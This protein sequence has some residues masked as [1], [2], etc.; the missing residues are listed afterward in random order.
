MERQARDT[1]L[2]DA[3]SNI[4]RPYIPPNKNQ[5]PLDTPTSPLPVTACMRPLCQIR[6]LRHFFFSSLKRSL[7]TIL[8]ISL[9]R[10]LLV[11]RRRYPKR[12][13][14]RTA[15]CTKIAPTPV[16]DEPSGEKEASRVLLA[17]GDRTTTCTSKLVQYFFLFQVDARS[18]R[19]AAC[20]YIQFACNTTIDSFL[21]VKAW[22]ADRTPCA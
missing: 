19:A 12:T 9:P 11:R 10:A 15:C 22:K 16:S 20:I 7:Q 8:Q 6:Q 21:A 1:N 3:I 14:G 4:I 18:I 5:N 2:N 13:L 17:T